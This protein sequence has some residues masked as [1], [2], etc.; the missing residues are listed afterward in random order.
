MGP[1]SFLPPVD[2]PERKKERGP[3]WRRG[4]DEA[5]GA[6]AAKAAFFLRP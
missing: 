1:L 4:D 6:R 2:A 3:R 5:L